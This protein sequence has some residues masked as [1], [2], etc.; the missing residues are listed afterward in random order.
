MKPAMDRCVSCGGAVATL[1][2]FGPQPPCNRFLRAGEDDADRHP[3][4]LGQCD[5][6]G[7]VQLIDPMPEEM[8]RPRFAWLSY[9][10]PEGHLD[11]LVERLAE[12]PPGRDARVAGLTYKDDSTVARLS[13]LGS[14]QTVRLDAA[15][16]LGMDDPVAGLETLQGRLSED[17]ARSIA[18]RYGQVDLLIARHV[19]EHARDP[20]SFA[21]ALAPLVKAG[22][23]VVFEVPDSTKFLEACDYSF[24]WEEHVAYFSAATLRALLRGI[25]GEPFEILTYPYPLEDSLV[26][27]V[28]MNASAAPRATEGLDVELARGRRFAARFGEARERYRGHL[29]ARRSAGRRLTLFGAGH[30]AATFLNLFELGEYFE[31]VIDD[32]PDKQELLMPG[33]GLPIRGSEILDDDRVDLCLLTLSPE[34]EQKVLA[35]R[36]AYRARGGEFRSIFALSPIALQV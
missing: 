12:L 16:D 10:E 23:H 24:L 27:I 14:T 29:A 33:S 32:H 6:C 21:R 18:A 20:R 34:S 3:L 17:R 36:E 22:G 1:I 31:C 4:T 13:R 30:L 5:A 15:Q 11:A 9:N 19:L 25:G 2:G 28:R 7:L 26:A 35:A 8:V